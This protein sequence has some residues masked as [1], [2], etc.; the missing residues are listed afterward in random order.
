MAELLQER[1]GHLGSGAAP[2]T[3]Q[4]HQPLAGS[5]SNRPM[6]MRCSVLTVA[7]HRVPDPSGFLSAARTRS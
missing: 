5:L 1:A 3:P 6:Y 7:R 2:H 4:L